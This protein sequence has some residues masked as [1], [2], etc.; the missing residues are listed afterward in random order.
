MAAGSY[1]SHR[2]CRTPRRPLMYRSWCTTVLS[3]A[4]SEQLEV[5]RLRRTLRARWNHDRVAAICGAKSPLVEPHRAGSSRCEFST[6][7]LPAV[8][9]LTSPPPR[10]DDEIA[11]LAWLTHL[12]STGVC[13]CAVRALFAHGV[14]ALPSKWTAPG[15]FWRSVRNRARCQTPNGCRRCTANDRTGDDSPDSLVTSHRW[16]RMRVGRSLIAFTSDAGRPRA[17]H[18]VAPSSILARIV[19]TGRPPLRS[20]QKNAGRGSPGVSHRVRARSPTRRVLSHEVEP[21][22]QG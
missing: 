5:R 13:C 19:R 11:V 16:R 6:R 18:R 15:N 14:T 9:L 21:A 17:A 2:R 3:I 7:F 4:V 20:V 10:V 8:A 1:L 22:R 12:L